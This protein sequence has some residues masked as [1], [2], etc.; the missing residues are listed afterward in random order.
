MLEAYVVHEGVEKFNANDRAR[1][2]AE[3]DGRSDDV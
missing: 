1:G 3:V 2:A